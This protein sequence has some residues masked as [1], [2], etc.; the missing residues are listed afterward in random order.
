MNRRRMKKEKELINRR[1]AQYS[2][3]MQKDFITKSQ[4]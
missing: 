2:R 4:M 3:Q 1:R